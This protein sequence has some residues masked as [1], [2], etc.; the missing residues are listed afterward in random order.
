VGNVLEDV[1][2]DIHLLYINIDHA[3][4]LNMPRNKPITRGKQAEQE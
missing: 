3:E 2:M 4:N 1:Q